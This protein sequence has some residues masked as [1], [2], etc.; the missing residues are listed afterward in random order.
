MAET[1]LVH[2]LR[3]EL[4]IELLL[5]ILLGGLVGWERETTGKAAGLRTHILICMGSAMFADLSHRMVNEGGDPGRIAAQIVTGVG[6]LGAG[7]ILHTG[8]RVKGLTTAASIWVVT[9][10]G[11]CLGFGAYLDAVAAAILV[12]VVLRGLGALESRIVRRD[13]SGA[14]AP[15]PE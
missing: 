8:E 1:G 3:I 15:R 7:A 12:Y 11:V 2:Q 9:A 13:E 5:A 6:F 14:A 4:V 10:I